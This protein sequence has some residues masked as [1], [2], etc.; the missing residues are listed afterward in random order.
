MAESAE[1]KILFSINDQHRTATLREFGDPDAPVTVLYFHRFGG[2]ALEFF[3]PAKKLV[4]A[5]YHVCALEYFGHEASEW[6]HA[7]EYDPAAD[8]ACAASVIR[9]YAPKPVLVIG[10]GWGGHIALRALAPE[11][12][13][14]LGVSLF[15]YVNTVQFATDV[16][17]P[18]EHAL[19]SISAPTL[20]LFRSELIS[21]A[22]PY[23]RFGRAMVSLSGQRVRKIGEVYTLPVDAAAYQ[24][25]REDPQRRYNSGGYLIRM[26]APVSIINGRLAEFRNLLN[27]PR[28]GIK[29]PGKLSTFTS[30]KFGFLTWDSTQAIDRIIA[31]LDAATNKERTGD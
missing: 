23:G 17:M 18:L 20:D 10:N 6:L 21:R 3:E 2:G 5:G 15:D 31:F 12:K 11:P 8:V 4:A 7:D 9:E 13:N 19:C 16:V 27:P 25:F 28:S 22:G 26:Q 29:I 1:R 30:P 14:L 24:P